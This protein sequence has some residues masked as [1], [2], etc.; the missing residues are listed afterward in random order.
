VSVSFQLVLIRAPAGQ[1]GPILAD[2]VDPAEAARRRLIV[3]DADGLDFMR[4][5]GAELAFN[6]IGIGANAPVLKENMRQ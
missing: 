4:F 5:V 2:F 1:E 6:Q 3:H